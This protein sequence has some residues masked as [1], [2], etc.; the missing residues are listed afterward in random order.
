MTL[1]LVAPPASEPVSRANAKAFLK[2]EHDDEDTLI[3]T[4]IAAAR[5]HVEAAT[6]RVLV[7][8]GWRLVLDGWPPRRL[9]ELPLSPVVSIDSVTVYDAGGNPAILDASA[10]VA[11]P[12]STPARLLVREAVAPSAA[13]NGIEIDF[14][15][16]YGEAAEDVP[17]PLAQAVLQLVAHWYE[18]RGDAVFG[19]APRAAPATVGA[20][21]APYRAV[22]L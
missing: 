20:L 7:A 19:G 1:I 2:V 4:L 12:L 21:V 11:D 10:W 17:A 9:I 16:G 14:T 15:A 5:L 18:V 8:Q 22:S 6:R 3:D 13:F